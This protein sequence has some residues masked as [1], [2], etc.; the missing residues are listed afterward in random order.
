MTRYK[1]QSPKCI[2]SP[3]LAS[4]TMASVLGTWIGGGTGRAVAERPEL[5][6]LS[7]SRTSISSGHSH[8]LSLSSPTG[9]LNLHTRANHLISIVIRRQ[10]RPHIRGRIPI[11]LFG[12]GKSSLQTRMEDQTHLS[13]AYQILTLPGNTKLGMKP[14]RGGLRLVHPWRSGSLGF[15]ICVLPLQGR[16]RCQPRQV[17]PFSP[18][19]NAKTRSVWSHIDGSNP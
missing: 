3:P 17:L 15:D 13:P 7:H 8:W 14:Y 9:M 10:I 18:T 16:L 19:L 11:V 6:I 4:A 1:V 2:P 12:P 5:S